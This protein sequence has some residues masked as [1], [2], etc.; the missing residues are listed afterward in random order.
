MVGSSPLVFSKK[1]WKHTQKNSGGIIHAGWDSHVSAKPGVRNSRDAGW[2][3]TRG[4]GLYTRGGII[5]AGV[6]FSRKCE[7]SCKKS[8]F[9]ENL[10]IPYWK[11]YR[12]F[13]QSIKEWAVVHW[14]SAKNHENTQKKIPVVF[15]VRIFFSPPL[16]GGVSSD[17]MLTW[18]HT[19]WKWCRYWSY[20]W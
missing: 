1:P 3:Y 15:Q 4:V 18:N 9:S 16:R 17:R 19:I 10:K 5:H 12:N 7:T 13:T 11:H 14:F 8:P 2:D 6:G 20:Y